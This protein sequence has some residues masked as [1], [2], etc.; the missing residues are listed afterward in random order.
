MTP[1]ITPIPLRACADEFD[2][3]NSLIDTG[4]RHVG[5]VFG[6]DITKALNLI[7]PPPPPSPD[8]IP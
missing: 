2:E 4:M 6:R 7:L 3:F 8:T 1:S 5:P